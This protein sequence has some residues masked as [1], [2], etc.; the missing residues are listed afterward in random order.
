MCNFIIKSK[1]IHGNRYDYSLTEYKGSHHKVK[2]ICPKHGMFE[3]RASSHISGRGCKKCSDEK[4]KLSKNK[5]LEKL[6][7]VNF[8]LFSNKYDYSLVEYI[9]SK[10]KIKIICKEHGVF[11]QRLDHHLNG[12]S[13]PNCSG[14]KKLTQNDFINKSKKTHG[15]KYDYT[16]VK[17]INNIT[18]VKI[19]CPRHGMFE[20]SPSNHMLGKGCKKCKSNVFTTDDF[21]EKSKEIHGDK[22]DYSLVKYINSKT[23][24]KI[25]CKNHGVF[26][27]IPCNHI[28][29][30]MKQGC[31]LCNESKGE[32][33]IKKVLDKLNIFYIQEYKIFEENKKY[34]LRA[35]F[36]I[37]KF[38]TIIEF[39]GIQHYK[40]VEKF[41]GK[42]IFKQTIERDVRKK[43]ICDKN[44]IKIINIKYND[45]NIVEKILLDSIKNFL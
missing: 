16:S 35:D 18:K 10:T 36:Y 33:E 11:E 27:Q 9:N 42:K 37:P 2:I 24:V 41:G 5:I 3:Q 4:S 13:C 7:I 23:K 22:Y 30:R 17:Y 38:N 44:N 34:P 19:I 45:I 8:K 6:N 29:V 43:K 32:L 31:P 12:S 25:I 15:D 28:H 39:N 40:P 14:N 1:E 20:Q 26:E 21:I